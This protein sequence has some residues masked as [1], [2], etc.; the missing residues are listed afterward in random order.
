M[1]AAF[2]PRPGTGTSTMRLLEFASSCKR[3]DEPALGGRDQ[4][5]I[6]RALSQGRGSR[7]DVAGR[8][9]RRSLSSECPKP[10]A[11]T[12]ENR[13]LQ[14]LREGLPADVL[15]RRPATRSAALFVSMETSRVI[16]TVTPLSGSQMPVVSLGVKDTQLSLIEWL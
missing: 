7:R 11:I 9:S 5:G 8:T 10:P 2:N 14:S 15:L 13:D 4:S 1:S 6:S 3:A 16:S 12:P